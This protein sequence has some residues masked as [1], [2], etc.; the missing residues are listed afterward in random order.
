MKQ[1]SLKTLLEAGA[2]FGHK[3]S[4]WQPASKPFIFSERDNI[5]IIDLTKTKEQ[6]EK[7]GE[8]VAEI[9]KGGGNILFIGTKRQA[10]KTVREIAQDAGIP[11]M[12]QRW[13]GGMITNWEQVKK[14]IS[15]MNDMEEEEKTG[16]WKKLP[17]HEQVKKGQELTKLSRV[18]GG[19]AGLAELPEAVYIV[20]IRHEV[21][22]VREAKRAGLV[23]IGIC[24][25]NSDPRQV[26]IPIPANDDAAGSIE[27][28]TSY[29]AEA[30]VEGKSK[31][32]S[33]KSK[34][35]VKS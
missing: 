33:Q 23:S 11:F 31:V 14:S 16:E 18:Y 5:H 21:T 19:V 17:K 6:L 20:D 27:Y 35:Q 25:T 32:K 12:T 24:D 22:A 8:K 3:A 34:L 29:L 26:T 28:I 2:H 13:I 10:A 4:R 30:F 9:A 15:L 7:A 1:V